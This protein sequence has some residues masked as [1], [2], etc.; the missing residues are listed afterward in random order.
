M[1]AKKY[2][3]ALSDEERQELKELTSKGQIQARKMKRAQVLLKADEGLKDEAICTAGGLLG[4][5]MRRDIKETC[6]GQTWPANNG[7]SVHNSSSRR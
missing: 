7:S 5:G 1:P 3:V 2:K 6:G 4:T